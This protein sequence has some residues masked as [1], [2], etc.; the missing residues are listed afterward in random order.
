MCHSLQQLLT[1]RDLGPDW[2]P[3]TRGGFG[4]EKG[5][6]AMV[7]DSW[8]TEMGRTA[9]GASAAAVAAGRH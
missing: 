5:K 3:L 1:R 4:T 6:V 2:H 7:A 8:P 9:V